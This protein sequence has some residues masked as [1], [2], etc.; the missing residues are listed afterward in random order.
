MGAVRVQALH[1]DAAPSTLVSPQLILSLVALSCGL[2]SISELLGR[3]QLHETLLCLRTDRS[4][5]L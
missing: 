1:W 5:V 2:F 3:R 4:P